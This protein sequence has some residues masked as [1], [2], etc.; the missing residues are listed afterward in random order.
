MLRVVGFQARG[1]LWHSRA[2]APL[3]THSKIWADAHVYISARAMY[4]NPLDWNEMLAWR[5]ALSPGKLFVD[6]GA[7]LGLYTIWA[8][9]LGADVI[10]IEPSRQSLARLE[11]NLL[12]NGYSAQIVAAAMGATT[13]TMA[14]T[15]A[16]DQQNHLLLEAH[17]PDGDHEVVA[18]ET[19]DG[20]V[21]DR[22]VHG[23]KID[24]E[25]A[26]ALVLAGAERLLAE[27]RA[28][29]IQLEWNEASVDLLGQDREPLR[30]LL[31]DHGYEFCRPD[32]Q[33]DLK[34]TNGKGFGSDVFARPRKGV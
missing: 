13:G 2:V 34:P 28:R 33:G 6:V 1:R 5:K 21:G 24:V 17:C 11:E 10:A 32:R 29:L 14:L 18:V 23:L 9:D 4:G 16:L 3:G 31:G 22:V 30:E 12:L 15:T 8:L 20:V 7:N 25:G 27:H 26:E 19:L